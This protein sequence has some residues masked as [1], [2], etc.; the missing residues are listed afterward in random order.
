MRQM[1]D[2][3][4]VAL[5]ALVGVGVVVPTLRITTRSVVICPAAVGRCHTHCTVVWRVMRCA[6]LAAELARAVA[7][8]CGASR[9]PRPSTCPLP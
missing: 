8:G 3:C 5:C 6:A 7:A 9:A 1:C 4:M 2:A